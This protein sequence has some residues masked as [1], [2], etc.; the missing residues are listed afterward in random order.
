M[1]APPLLELQG[2]TVRRGHTLVLD[3]C[4]LALQPGTVHVLVGPNGAGK[5][6]L[7]QVVLGLVDFDGAARFNF[8]ASCRIAYVPQQFSG[9]ERLPLTVAEFLALERQR[10]PVCLGVRATSRARIARALER[11][12]LAGFENRRIDRI[13]GGERQRVLLANAIEPDPEIVLLDEPATGLDRGAAEM[14]EKTIRELRANGT[15]V[16]MVSH[17]A[18]QVARLADE[19]TKLGAMDTA[20][21]LEGVG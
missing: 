1:S 15:A 14:L 11:V 21:E 8:R 10:W 19:V 9:A 4:S 2:V 18:A 16:L 6:T 7:L 5:S 17:D 20:R 3:R 12:G 13:S